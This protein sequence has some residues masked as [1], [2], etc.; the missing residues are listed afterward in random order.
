MIRVFVGTDELQKDA[1][2]VLEYSI[3]KNT[4]EDV[5]LT[6]MRPG[7]KTPPTGFASHRYLI[8]KLCN[9]RGYAIY[10]DS[11][12][13]VLGDLSELW[14]YQTKDKW[15]VTKRIGKQGIRDEV[16][17][18]D[19]SAFRDLPGESQL[20]LAQG[21]TIAKNIIGD[22]YLPIIPNT[23]NAWVLSECIG[24]CP[25]NNPDC[26]FKKADPVETPAKLLHYTNLST[27]PWHPDPNQ[28]YIPFPC[29]RTEDVF[30]KYLEEAKYEL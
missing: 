22:R 4:T 26:T 29:K 10:L 19:C 17:V 9:Y 21:K 25:T 20:K 1:E 28:K 3:R 2:R 18:I 5:N 23:W 11:D 12:M 16:S 13:L 24:R 15:C 27:Q 14:D 8:P 7:W 30:W 6:F